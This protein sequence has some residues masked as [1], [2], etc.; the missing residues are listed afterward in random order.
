[1]KSGQRITG[2]WTRD[3]RLAYQ[4]A[5]PLYHREC[6]LY[7]SYCWY[8]QWH[9]LCSGGPFINLFIYCFFQKT[10]LKF[11]III[12]FSFKWNIIQGLLLL[13]IS[14]SSFY[15]YITTVP[16]YPQT[17]QHHTT[18]HTTT[19]HHITP[20]NTT[21][22]NPIPPHHTTPQQH[23]HN[24]TTTTTLQQHH[25]NTTTT[26]QHHHSTITTPPQHYNTT[27][28][29]SHNTKTLPSLT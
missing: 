1:M 23:H 19:P 2:I 21:L 10:G 13:I 8:R 28:S 4:S 3:L 6:S 5:R 14:G 27:T 18:S 24:T 17:P 26:L 7:C 25:N 22:H 11:L 15:I 29:P 9:R 20:H 12:A 16:F